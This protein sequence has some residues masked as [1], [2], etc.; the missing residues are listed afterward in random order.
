MF[1]LQTMA[2]QSPAPSQPSRWPVPRWKV[3][4]PRARR[5]RSDHSSS[6]PRLWRPANSRASRLLDQLEER[7]FVGPFEG[8][9]PRQVMVTKAQWDEMKI[10]GETVVGAAAPPASDPV[11]DELA[12]LPPEY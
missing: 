12:D 6:V 1:S 4:I 9:K 8:S 7:G 3:S 2:G 10:N 5:Q 11:P